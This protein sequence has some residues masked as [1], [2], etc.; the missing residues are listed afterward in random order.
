MQ[1]AIVTGSAKGIGLAISKKLL[2]RK[3]FVVMNYANDTENAELVT[4]ELS[5]D[6][7]GQF[8]MIHQKLETK[9]DVANFYDKYKAVAGSEAGINLLVLN[10]GCTD[11]TSWEKLTWEDFAHVMDVNVNAPA[12]L[13][14]KLHNDLC[15]NGN[16]IMIST[17]M[18]VYPHAIS[19]PYTVSKSALNGLTLALVKEYCS[20]NIRVNAVLPGFVE[21]PWQ[22]RKPQDQRKRICDK[23]ALNRFAEPEE[24]AQAVM[25]IID[26]SYINGALIP[27][28]GSYCYR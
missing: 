12:E 21:T 22:K 2:G 27:V 15:D 14:R 16:I 20:R 17:I 7:S 18:G 10:A 28:D 11:R 1:T 13:I 23:I 19:V 26:S 3:Y 8:A 25:G 9:D 4:K 5:S 24:I 6:Y